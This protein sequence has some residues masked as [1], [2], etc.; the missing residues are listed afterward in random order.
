[1]TYHNKYKKTTNKTIGCFIF[2]L[3]K[4]QKITDIKTLKIF[5]YQK[6]Y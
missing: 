2:Y 1:M 3:K 5:L 6:K 4:N